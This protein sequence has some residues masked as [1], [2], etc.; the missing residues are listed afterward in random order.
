MYL[1]VVVYKQTHSLNLMHELA[2]SYV[3]SVTV[4]YTHST[5]DVSRSV[6][7]FPVSSSLS[8]V[9]CWPQFYG[10]KRNS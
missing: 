7:L 6:F 9:L 10:G 3:H 8:C 4:T 5:T 1:L 2:R